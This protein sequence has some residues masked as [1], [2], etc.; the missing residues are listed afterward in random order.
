MVEADP[1][2][3]ACGTA[4]P[5][6]ATCAGR[7][8]QEPHA[9]EDKRAIQDR[10]E[11]VRTNDILAVMPAEKPPS[12]PVVSD[13][14][15]GRDKKDPAHEVEEGKER[16]SPALAPTAPR[17]SGVR[18]PGE[19]PKDLLEGRFEILE[20]IGSGGMG[21]VFRAM[22]HELGR[23]VAVKRLNKIAAARDELI[24]RFHL[25]AK[26][27][28]RLEDP[29]IVDVR[30]VGRDE[31]GH[32][33]FVTEFVQG[34]TVRQILER[35]GGFSVDRALR[36][37]DQLLKT[38][39][40]IHKAGVVHRDIKPSNLML[41]DDDANPDL[42]KVLDF[43][44]AKAREGI[45]LTFENA[46]TGTPGFVAPEYYLAGALRRPDSPQRD[47]YSAGIVLYELLS[48][49]SP[50][51][52]MTLDALY[53]AQKAGPIPCGDGMPSEVV[54]MITKATE[55]NPDK[56][57]ATAGEF[58]A[59][60][61]RLARELRRSEEA[62]PDGPLDI[63][64]LL[65]G[66]V[67]DG[68]YVVERKIGQGGMGVVYVARD[69]KL[70]RRCALK[71]FLL[72]GDAY[73][74]ELFVR[75]EREG[76]T[77]AEVPHA[78]VVGVYRQHVWRGVPYIAMEYVDGDDLRARWTLFSWSDLVRV[79]GQVA[80]GLDVIHARSIVHRDLSPE[81]IVIERATGQA[82]VIDFGIARSSSSSLTKTDSSR[83]VGRWGYL[84]P[85]QLA[86]PKR[87]TG[88]ADQFS[89][90][91]IVYEALVGKPPFC[92]NEDA[93]TSTQDACARLA[94]GLV[95]GEPPRPV[96]DTNAS[97]SPEI[98]AVVGRALASEPERRFATATEFAVALAAAPT[99]NTYLA[100]TPEEKR[101]STHS[102][103]RILQGEKQT[104]PG[105]V[106][107][108]S[109]VG[110][111]GAATILVVVG[112]VIVRGQRHS[113]PAGISASIPRAADA[114]PW[115]VLK[116]MG[117]EGTGGR[118]GDAVDASVARKAVMVLVSSL[119]EVSVV[120]EGRLLRLPQTLERPVGSRLRVSA[121][122][123]GYETQE[124]DLVFEE[125]EMHTVSVHL[126]RRKSSASRRRRDVS[127][128]PS[129]APPP[130]VQPNEEAPPE[131][132]RKK[133]KRSLFLEE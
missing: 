102:T 21:D 119:E 118:S 73:D 8:R 53:L 61:Q 114:A 103:S 126:E 75:F 115:P 29:N 41:L 14:P 10:T 91:A 99:S 26:N 58:R 78:N 88:R 4:H 108:R 27:Q 80:A 101:S 96:R 123:H 70:G 43:G 125:G 105:A 15:D 2:C 44:I 9:A 57:Y 67:V 68:V 36:V 51:E 23:Q 1:R 65:T 109:F 66:T 48:G 59:D 90:A 93:A 107:R 34:R 77:T 128:P 45:D 22:D 35:E 85:E 116:A 98:E 39:S 37:M 46:V 113:V 69:Q 124:L 133:P 24:S 97:V 94:Q 42:L 7:R 11:G 54:A 132:P 110:A 71:F 79:V 64:S 131:A 84:A 19:S 38:L 16:W 25:E 95:S 89:L 56:R 112:F 32:P 5:G 121:E 104:R 63:S 3:P 72:D 81:N 83:L 82:K 18:S 130:E 17:R 87:V 28:A 92:E 40:V 100:W 62:A 117:A 74:R 129:P 122:K 60:I 106:R 47:V 127:E 120:V 31:N 30:H 13:G 49:T 20:R 12:E 52:G 33:F 50:W 55:A 6:E 111:A 86:D 76:K